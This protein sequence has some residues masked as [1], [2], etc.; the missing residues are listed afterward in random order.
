MRI[1]QRARCPK[2]GQEIL[3]SVEGDASLR[4]LDA[5]IECA[6]CKT[7]I[8]IHMVNEVVA[9]PPHP[10][11]PK[12]HEARRPEPL[13]HPPIP[14]HEPEPREPRLIFGEG[15]AKFTNVFES[16]E[17]RRLIDEEKD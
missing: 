16:D 13:H 10:P 6:R 8:H 1:E 17:I 4:N 5:R 11:E 7:L 9:E 14:P 3:F 12:P 15:I 2:C